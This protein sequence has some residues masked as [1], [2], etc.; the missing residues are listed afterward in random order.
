[1][2]EQSPA[3]QLKEEQK[4]LDEAQAKS[5][6]LAKEIEARKARVAELT[7]T[8]SEIEQ[9]KNA[10]ETAVKAAS[11]QAGKS[12][13][14]VKKQ[15]PMLEAIVDEE[16]LKAAK[17]AGE[18]KLA[19]LAK[20]VEAASAAVDKADAAYLTAKATTAAKQ[21]A[22]TTLT[23]L[24]SANEAVVKDLT[25]L[26]IA[27][28][29]DASANAHPRAYVQVLFIEDVVKK[30]DLRS[31]DDYVAALN[32]AGAAVSAATQVERVAKETLDA[33]KETRKQAQQKLD[34]ARLKWRED[35]LNR[36]PTYRPPAPATSAPA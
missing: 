5:G 21:A 28:D 24:A 18:K 12:N 13:A 31:A 30:L 6:V 27:A 36:L 35:V 2:P 16:A 23:N 33:A 9:K 20:E 15:K 7:K 25:A 8:A 22:Y 10:W 29:K 17:E 19:D 1:M 26:Q 34:A 11:E 4:K 32:E 14:Y 3:E